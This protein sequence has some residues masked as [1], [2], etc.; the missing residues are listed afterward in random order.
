[1]NYDT[2]FPENK[3]GIA[4]HSCIFQKTGKRNSDAGYCC[5]DIFYQRENADMYF[6]GLADGQSGKKYGAV[7][8]LISLE[9][10][11]DY[12][13]KWGVS[14]LVNYRFPD[15]LPGNFA[16]EIRRSLMLRAE[17]NCC[18]FEEYSS[19]LLVMAIDPLTAQYLILHLGDGCAMEILEDGSHVILSGPE[20]GLTNHHTW[21]T[22]TKN[23]VR[24]IRI[25]FGSFAQKKRILLCS[26]GVQQINQGKNLMWR[27]SRE[28]MKSPEEIKVYL[29]GKESD[30]DS[31]CVI[32]DVVPNNKLILGQSRLAND[33]RGV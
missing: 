16:R 5:Q 28:M 12:V 23:M 9:T 8:G 27:F 6:Y 2:D 10:I 13:Q 1:M 4:I 14:T 33:P 25:S 3:E 22:T 20:N 15:E 19:T 11:A 29:E 17:E 18:D 26:D 24:H 7:G 30:D 21:L 32:L 31:S